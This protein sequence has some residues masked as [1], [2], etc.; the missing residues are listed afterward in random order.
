M[1]LPYCI[2]FQNRTHDSSN[3]RSYTHIFF[4]LNLDTQ[5]ICWTTNE[6]SATLSTIKFMKY[7]LTYVAA[8]TTLTLLPGCA[9]QSIV[10]PGSESLSAAESAYL[11]NDKG[12]KG[13]W[14]ELNAVYPIEGGTLIRSESFKDYKSIKVKPGTYRVQ[15]KVRADG[16][17]AAFPIATVTVKPGKTYLFSSAF[18]M[19]GSAIRAHYREIDSASYKEE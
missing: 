10:A 6:K 18:A 16:Y 17:M 14:S 1:V 4:I 19:D 12:A 9:S 2:A 3:P 11:K 7:L 8:L 5:G 15:L 13:P